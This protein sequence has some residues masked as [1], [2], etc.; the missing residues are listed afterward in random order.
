MMIEESHTD[1]TGIAVGIFRTAQG[2]RVVDSP[3]RARILSLLGDGELS[4][5]EIVSETGRAK[6]TISVHLREMVADGV[7]GSRS[8][9]EDGRRKYFFLNSEYLGQLSEAERLEMDIGRLLEDYDPQS[10]DLFAF[11]RAMFTSIR[12]TL[13]A[14]GINI[15]P[16]LRSAGM[17]IGHALARILAGRSTGEVLETLARFWEKHG[18]GRIEVLS[19]SPIVIEIRD[20]FECQSLPVLGRPVCAFDSG[21]LTSVFSEHFG[22]A[23][24]VEETACYAMGD[25]YCRFV[26]ER[27]IAPATAKAA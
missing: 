4:F 9:P 24:S 17:H 2:L 20:C 11:Y 16:I 6:S 26:I 1:P 15:D 23:P 10:S 5:D 8:D 18:L 14:D 3:T 12:I 27:A 7:L 21:V 22:A 25:G 13:L 19:L